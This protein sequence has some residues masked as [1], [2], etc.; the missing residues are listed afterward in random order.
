MLGA[1]GR[2]VIFAGSFMNADMGIV[3]NAL[4]KGA[5]NMFTVRCWSRK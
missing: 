1:A 5:T 2:R 3:N 4:I